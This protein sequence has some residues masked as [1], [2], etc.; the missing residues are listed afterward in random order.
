M[1]T[2]SPL[3]SVSHIVSSTPVE[4]QYSLPLADCERLS[5]LDPG[6]CDDSMHTMGQFSPLTGVSCRKQ[7][8]IYLVLQRSGDLAGAPRARQ[9]R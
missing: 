9:A 1:R 5:H 7:R 2:P 4:R 3:L 6:F 8:D